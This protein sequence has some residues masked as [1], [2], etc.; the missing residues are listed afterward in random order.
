MY[1][2]K[3]GVSKQIGD[4]IKFGSGTITRLTNNSTSYT[5][6]GGAPAAT[7]TNTLTGTMIS[8]VNSGFQI[9]I[10]ADRS[11]RTVQLFVGVNKSR[12]RL[13]ASLS[14]GSQPAISSTSTSNTSG[15]SNV[16][17]TIR[18]ASG[19]SGQVLKLKWALQTDH[20]SGSVTLQAA[21]L[22]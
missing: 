11:M 6:T 15:R 16:V 7:A 1:N 17:Y 9:E 10:P 13:D 14:D 3:S 22:W 19:T 21:S 2:R 5:W 12:G 8:G 20:G 4:V 18:F